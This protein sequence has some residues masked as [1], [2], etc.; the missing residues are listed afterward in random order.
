MLKF[1]NHFKKSR[2]TDPLEIKT[3]QAR[4]SFFAFLWDGSELDLRIVG[5][6]N[7]ALVSRVEAVIGPPIVTGAAV[8]AGM[9]FKPPVLFVNAV[10]FRR[11]RSSGD[12]LI[13]LPLRSDHLVV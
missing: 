6:A 4:H 2:P 10:E 7:H 8:A 9:V 3:I 12:I 11:C 13:D 1:L 5:R